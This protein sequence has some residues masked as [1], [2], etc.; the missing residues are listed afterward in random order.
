MDSRFEVL[1]QKLDTKIDGLRADLATQFR[2]TI[3]IMMA[4]VTGVLAAVLTR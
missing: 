2:W 3:G 4:L 1:D